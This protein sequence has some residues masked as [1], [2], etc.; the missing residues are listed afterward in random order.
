MSEQRIEKCKK[1][2]AQTIH[3]YP[4]TSHLLHFILT[5]CTLGFW[6]IIWILIT[7]SN[8]FEGK[9]TECSSAKQLTLQNQIKC[10]DC[11]ELVLKEARKCKHCGRALQ[12]KV[13]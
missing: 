11:A 13:S 2:N 9:C 12:P 3:I 7:I 8:D 4:S 1:C 10:P 6:V 5:L